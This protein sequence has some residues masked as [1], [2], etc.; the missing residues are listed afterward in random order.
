MAEVQ[1]AMIT[2]RVSRKTLQFDEKEK[3]KER[4]SERN[5]WLSSA[6]SNVH[7]S[8]FNARTRTSLVKLFF[9]IVKIS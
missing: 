7:S 2:N 1:S 3:Q 4:R 8:A 6:P 5:S 9:V